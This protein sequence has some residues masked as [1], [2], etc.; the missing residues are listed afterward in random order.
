ME[1]YKIINAFNIQIR[2]M[3]EYKRNCKKKKTFFFKS[4][5]RPFCLNKIIFF[6]MCSSLVIKIKLDKS[7]KKN[8]AEMKMGK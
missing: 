5:C 6:L 4:I 8:K 2:T 3:S 1:I 7:E